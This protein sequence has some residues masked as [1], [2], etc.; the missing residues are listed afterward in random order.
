MSPLEFGVLQDLFV[1]TKDIHFISDKY[2]V[3]ESTIKEIV[4]NVKPD[5][6]FEEESLSLRGII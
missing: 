1:N 3:S 2:Q 6:Q 4:F 5:H